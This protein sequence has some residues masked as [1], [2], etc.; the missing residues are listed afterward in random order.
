MILFQNAMPL[1]DYLAQARKKH[2][3]VGFVPT[4]GALHPRGPSGLIEACKKKRYCAVCSIFV[5]PTGNLTIPRFCSIDVRL[6]R[7]SEQ[8]VRPIARF[9]SCPSHKEIYPNQ[10]P[11]CI[12]I[13]VILKTVLEGTY[14]RGI[15]R[16]ARQ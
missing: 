14:R 13:L 10:I 1:S 2:L 16:R 8:L 4:M 9:C 7:M 3:T 6:E 15:F 12:T 5:N 11:H